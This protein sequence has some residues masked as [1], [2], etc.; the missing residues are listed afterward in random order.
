MVIKYIKQDN[1]VEEV[2]DDDLGIEKFNQDVKEHDDK[3][4][5]EQDRLSE[6]KRS[7]KAKESIQ[8]S[9]PVGVSAK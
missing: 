2:E 3:I 7:N 1:E 5:L 8:R 9:K 6:T 4:G